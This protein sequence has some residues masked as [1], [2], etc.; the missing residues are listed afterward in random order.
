MGG[1]LHGFKSHV[2]Y[3]GRFRIDSGI[4]FRVLANFNMFRFRAVGFRVEA[5]GTDWW[6]TFFLAL[7]CL[8]CQK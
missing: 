8:G 4:G 5:E 1:D 6:L 2:C 3:R 7:Q